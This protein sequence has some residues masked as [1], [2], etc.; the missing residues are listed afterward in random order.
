[1]HHRAGLDHFAH[2]HQQP[3]LRER[4]RRLR[5]AIAHLPANRDLPRVHIQPQ[6]DDHS[7][8]DESTFLRC[9]FSVMFH[10]PT[11]WLLLNRLSASCY[12]EP[13]AMAVTPRAIV[14]SLEVK[15]RTAKRYAARGAPATVVAHL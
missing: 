8:L 14:R 3:F 15:P 4:L 9:V 2:P 13:T 6:L 7:R 1:V 12:L 10:R 5:R 11:G